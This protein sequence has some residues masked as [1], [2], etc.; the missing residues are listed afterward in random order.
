[1]D[2]VNIATCIIL[3]PW[4]LARIT[5]IY[6]HHRKSDSRVLE[7]FSGREVAASAHCQTV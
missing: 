5:A 2:V 7:N 3:I 1:M 6:S 4:T